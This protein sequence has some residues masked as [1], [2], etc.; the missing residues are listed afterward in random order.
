[1]FAVEIVLDI[2][3]GVA[4]ISYRS[5]YNAALNAVCRG[6]KQRNAAVKSQRLSA[7]LLE[8]FDCVRS[9]PWFANGNSVLICNL[10]RPDYQAV[11]KFVF[12]TARLG[13][14]KSYGSLSR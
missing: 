13:D 10:V 9:R 6:V 3:S 2:L 8:L 1:M 12:K 5:Q 14:C 7:H 11:L 4:A